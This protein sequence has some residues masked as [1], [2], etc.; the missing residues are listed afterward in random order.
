MFAETS[1]LGLLLVIG[2]WTALIAGGFLFKLIGQKLNHWRQAR[3]RCPHGIKDGINGECPQCEQEEIDA[4]RKYYFAKQEAERLRQISNEANLLR[5]E[6]LKR[7][8]E[9]RTHSLECLLQLTPEEF[10]GAIA[11]MYVKFGYEATQ[12]PMSND[13]GRDVILKKD[14]K[15]IFVECKRYAPD[16]YIGRPALQKIHSA[17]ITMKADSGIVI[18][19]SDFAETAVRFA[20]ENQIEL[21]NGVKLIGKMVRAFPGA[22]GVNHYKAMCRQCRDVVIFDLREASH[23]VKCRNNHAVRRDVSLNDLTSAFLNETLY[24]EKCGAS[25]R[26][27][28]G[29]RG[30]FWGCSNYPHC[31]NTKQYIQNN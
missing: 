11:K 4:L 3:K 19:T 25:M 18:T 24:C 6:E 17:I 20:A 12:T 27:V 10:E 21:I 13:F 26:I 23:E 28:N 15:T 5:N 2:F 1:W 14:G 16:N 9:L 8:A 22:E 31:R 7:L 30:K 29:R